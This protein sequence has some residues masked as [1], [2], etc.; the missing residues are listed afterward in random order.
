[1]IS[2]IICSIHNDRFAAVAKN[3]SDLLKHEPH[4]IIRISD[5]RSLCEGYNRGI[6]ASRGD[7]LIFSHDD[8]EILTADFASRLKEHLAN[9]DLIGVA[10]TSRLLRGG[11]QDAGPPYI[12][13]QVA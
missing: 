3:Y 9:F 6:A 8:I 10:G 2:V 13:G 1:M 11:W 4:E 7:I 12:F 5:A